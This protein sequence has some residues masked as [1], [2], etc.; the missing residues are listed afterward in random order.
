MK[1]TIELIRVSTAEQAGEDRASIPAQRAVNRQTAV[2]YSLDIVRTIEL[3]DVSGAAVLKSSEM[4]DL[5]TSIQSPQIEG[6]VTR[7]FSRLMR[8]ENFADYAILQSFAESNTVLYLPDGPIDFTNKSGRLLG[9]IRAA[10]AGAERTEILERVWSAKEQKRRA[11]KM[12]Q[13]SIT[14]P[15]GVDYDRQTERW[16]YTTDA[17]RV[18]EAFRLF[19]AGNANYKCVGEIVGIVGTNLRIMLRNPIYAGWRVIDKKRDSSPAAHRTGPN[20]RQADRRKIM[21]P[22][23]EIIRVQVIDEPL[24]SMDEFQRVQAIMDAKKQGHWRALAGYEHRFVYNGFLNCAECGSLIYTHFRRR[25]YYICS[26][27][28]RH[29][30]CSTRYMRRESLEPE[31]DSL[32]AERFTDPRFLD[33]LSEAWLHRSQETQGEMN[34]IRLQ[35]ELASLKSKRERVLEMYI[36]GVISSTERDE[37][38]AGLDRDL[39]LFKE[40]LLRES[41][42]RRISAEQLAA[43]FE[44]FREWNFLGRED[45]RRLLSATMPAVYVR[46]YQVT[47]IKLPYEVFG[48]QVSHTDKGSL[49]QRA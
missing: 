28:V 13:S 32:L 2:R 43:V 19:L 14:L 44:P 24:I 26:G 23:E 4:Q 11:G 46:D 16:S 38:L 1:R 10:M 17:E 42:A 40:L 31:I 20:G 48:S 3:T 29:V 8:P 37:R 25:D 39:V 27:R 41:P 34:R 21:R 9:I 22:P 15:F 12:P 7:E 18:R 49:R 36:D 47:G 6:V 45:K 5:L 35:G 33:M 30:G